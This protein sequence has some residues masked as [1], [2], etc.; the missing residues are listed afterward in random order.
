MPFPERCPGASSIRSRA[1]PDEPRNHRSA[2]AAL[3]FASP[4]ACANL[5][6]LGA[7][8]H[9]PARAR[10]IATGGKPMERRGVLFA[11]L[12][13]VASLV[14]ATAGAE[15]QTRLRY[16]HVG[17]EGDIQYWFA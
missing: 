13:L 3:R 10:T 7:R 16:A 8:A 4:P 1:R 14:L 2:P 6:A 11:G 12:T 9:R 5:R 15:A 17:S